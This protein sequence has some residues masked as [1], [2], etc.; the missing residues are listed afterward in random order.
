M[1]FTRYI[2]GLIRA[3]DI[4]SHKRFPIESDREKRGS[5]FKPAG[6]CLSSFFYAWNVITRRS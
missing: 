2:Y 4:F 3:H 6:E 5:Y 1:V